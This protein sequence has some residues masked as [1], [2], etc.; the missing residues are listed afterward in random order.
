M[1]THTLGAAYTA[2]GAS[3]TVADG[4]IFSPGAVLEFE[5]GDLYKVTAVAD[6]VLTVI[7]NW[8]GTESEDHADGEHFWI[9]PRLS[10]SVI[11]QAL[12]AA[13]EAMPSFGIWRW[14]TAAITL[15]AD[16][17]F[18]EL[19]DT[20]Y[21]P[22][23]GIIG[24]YYPETTSLVPVAV[25]FR[26]FSLVHADVSSTG[27][28]VHL[29]EWGDRT[30]GDDIYITYSSEI[31]A[32]TDLMDRQEELVVLWAANYALGHTIIP[33]TMDPGHRTNQTI[34]GGQEVRDARWFQAQFYMAAKA[35]QALL[36]V[37][38]RKLVPQP[39]MFGRMRRWTW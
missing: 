35:E 25:P 19:S 16:Q 29:W 38:A 3:M 4:D 28:G 27:V 32:I 21:R 5:D 12:D 31:A 8:E 23:P 2:D 13:I 34:Q 1:Q 11:D 37:E 39:R 36:K 33:S 22:H 14:D 6:D 24:A 30:A 18:Y 15:V 20:D 26:P 9:D 17:Y 7:P 10:R